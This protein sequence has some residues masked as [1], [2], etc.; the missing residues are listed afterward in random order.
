MEQLEFRDVMPPVG[1]S[2]F[3]MGPAASKVYAKEQGLSIGG[4][5]EA[6]YTNHSGDKTSRFDFLRAVL[7][8]GYK[9]NDRWVFNSEIEFEHASTGEEGSAS[10][11]FAYLEYLH[12][13]PLNV[14]VGLLLV[15]MGFINEMH[16]PT[17][18]L[19]P[20]RP[21]TE[22]RIIPTT[23]REG[24][25]G[26][27]GDIGP[28]SYKAY[29]MAG[30]DASG[31]DEDGLRGGRQKGSKSKAEDLAF[32][33]RLDWTA[34]PGLLAGVS[35]YTGDSG[36]GDPALGDA[37]TMIFDLHAEYKW[38][39]LR[40]RGLYAQANVDDT[41]TLNAANGTTVGEKMTG[42]YLEAGYDLMGAFQP[43]SAHSVIPY[44]RYEDVNTHAS[45]APGYTADPAQHEKITTVGIDWLPIDQVVFKA[46]YQD[47]DQDADQLVLGMG[48]VF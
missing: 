10:V 24:G 4:Y 9:F 31:F 18:Y 6:V 41:E 13:D 42:W 29:V 15:P 20:I 27:L 39:G 30:L 7:Y 47:F 34:T 5:G 25:A 17:T 40:L 48:Y 23:W 28:F 45:V 11:E 16:E 14:R 38:R 22:N 26:L 1:D 21:L 43:D 46:A 36:Q 12:D 44:V 3:G 37:G 19:S 35:G 2:K 32:T 33:A 8:T